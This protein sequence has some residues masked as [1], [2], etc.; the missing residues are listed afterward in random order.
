MYG[1]SARFQKYIYLGLPSAIVSA[2]RDD[3]D[4]CSSDKCGNFPLGLG[5]IC[6]STVLHSMLAMT[7][8]RAYVV[9]ATF[10]AELILA[11]LIPITAFNR[12]M[13]VHAPTDFLTNFDFEQLDPH[14][15]RIHSFL[16]A[17]VIVRILSYTLE[18]NSLLPRAH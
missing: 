15:K 4:C 10:Y 16:P 9:D 12:L 13:W 14:A 7:P 17:G 5:K 8:D 18:T 1:G 2:C 6:G 11:W 3:D